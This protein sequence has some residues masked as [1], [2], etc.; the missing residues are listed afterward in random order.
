MAKLTVSVICD[1]KAK[2]RALKGWDP[3]DFKAFLESCKMHIHGKY[4]RM[5]SDEYIHDYVKQA[6]YMVADSYQ[7]KVLA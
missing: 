3:T 2:E 4:R 6:L 5:F 7:G 1:L